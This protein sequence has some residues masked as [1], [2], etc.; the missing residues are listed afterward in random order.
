MGYEDVKG[1]R[2]GD[3]GHGR[4]GKI[5]DTFSHDPESY[6]KHYTKDDH[7]EAAMIHHS[8]AKG[9]ELDG[10]KE[11]A[12]HHHRMAQWHRQRS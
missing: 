5:K 8:R 9:H 11:Q 12:D 10:R 3:V 1:F 2:I 4:G 6:S 7:A